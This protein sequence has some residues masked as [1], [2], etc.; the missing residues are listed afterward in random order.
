MYLWFS[1]LLLVVGLFQS[2]SALT[3]EECEPLVEPFST[4][5]PS[6]DGRWIYIMGFIDSEPFKA[7]KRSAKSLWVKFSPSTSS[8][9]DFVESVG[10]RHPGYCKY[11]S[12]PVT[13]VTNTAV[14]S[15]SNFTCTYRSLPTCKDC[16]VYTVDSINTNNALHIMNITNPTTIHEVKQYRAVYLMA[17]KTTVK[18]S[19][20]ER[21]KKQ[22]RCLGFTWEP[23]FYY[24]PKNTFCERGVE[25]EDVHEHYHD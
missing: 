2:S 15:K 10:I 9:R 25:H 3:P 17:K 7:L 14:V 4:F 18:A 11:A 6:Y 12:S 20:L 21:F 16:L 22:A 24:N 5:T 19:E 23:D 1:S 13:I 8:P